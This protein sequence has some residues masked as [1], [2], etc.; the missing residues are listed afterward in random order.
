MWFLFF[1]FFVYLWGQLLYSCLKEY[2]KSFVYVQGLGPQI[3]DNIIEKCAK[4][5]SAISEENLS[6]SQKCEYER[7]GE[8]IYN[9]TCALD[10]VAV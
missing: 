4:M 2:E 5:L 3:L 9:W 8:L 1:I 7:I 6:D 10:A